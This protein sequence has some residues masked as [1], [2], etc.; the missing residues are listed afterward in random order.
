MHAFGNSVAVLLT[1]RNG[2]GTVG[3]KCS[4]ERMVG[5]G[6]GK[7]KALSYIFGFVLF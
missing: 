6:K 4:G 5:M 1:L 7:R 3:N 2:W